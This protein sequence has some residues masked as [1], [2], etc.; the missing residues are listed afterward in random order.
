MT[1]NHLKKAILINV[2]AKN[3]D[4]ESALQNFHE[5]TR[6]VETYGGIVIAK[7]IQK[8][9]R[10]SAKTFL[11]EGK[12]AEVKQIAKEIGADLIIIDDFLKAN[13]YNHLIKIFGQ[14]VWDRFETILKI[15]GKH[16]QSKQAKLQIELTT[17][18]YEFPKLFGKGASLSQQ[19]GHIGVRSGAGEKLLELKRRHL[20]R[21][22][23]Q[24]ESELEKLRKVKQGQ[25]TRRQRNN[26]PIIAIIGYT[27]SGKSTLLRSLTGKQTYIADKLFATLDTKLGAT[28]LKKNGRKV[29]IS[30]TIGFIKNLPPI[31]FECFLTT[32]E[33][34]QNADMLIHLID[35]SDPDMQDKMKTVEETL[36]QINCDQ[37]EKI[38]V[39]N[40]IDLLKDKKRIPEITEKYARYH[41]VFISATEKTNLERLGIKSIQSIELYAKQK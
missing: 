39:F 38:L 6:L 12:I 29:L 27:N 4:R 41:P 10:P 23:D 20:R 11:G 15:F 40:K 16:A 18:K 28:F 24:I 1:T 3:A 30:D 37:K 17:L 31:L 22:I 7:I 34:I 14:E 5:L 33:E 26:L 36:K 32:L 21:R 2:I 19:A 8:R 13:Q 35:I 25:H 9:N